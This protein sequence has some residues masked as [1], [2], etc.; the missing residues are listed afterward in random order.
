[1]ATYDLP[2]E[3]LVSGDGPIRTVTLNRPEHSNAINPALH[4]ALGRV[5]IQLHD[6]PDAR[7]VVLTGAGRAFSAGGDFDMI[8]KDALDPEFRERD[9]ADARRIVTEMISFPLPVIAAVNGAAVGLGCS[10]AIMS[11]VVLMSEKAFFADPHVS[12]GLVAADGGALAWPML[13]SLLKAKE[14]VLTGDRLDAV[15]AERIGL[16]NHVVSAD[17]LMDRAYELADRLAA[18]P[19]QALQDT[20]RALNLHLSRAVSG[21]LD[22]AFAAES[23]SFTMPDFLPRLDKYAPK[24]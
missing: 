10:L 4:R 12:I 24:P 13:T 18:Q 15:T 3:L 8:R 17:Q 11:D 20:K 19:R 23:E 21:V 16:A 2:D 7:V 22:F 9:V 5:W 1:M 6:D 14:Y